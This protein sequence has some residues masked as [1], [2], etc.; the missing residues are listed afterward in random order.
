MATER[1]KGQGRKSDSSDKSGRKKASGKSGWSKPDGTPLRKR[2]GD[3]FPDKE[4]D[5]RKPALRGRYNKSESF[6]KD[7]DNDRPR[8]YKRAEGDREARSSDSPRE[9]KK[10]GS[11]YRDRDSDK[12][13]EYSRTEGASGDR[14]D[15]PREYKKSGTGFRDRDSKPRPENRFRD[16]DPKPGEYKKTGSKYG[17]FKRA[18]FS[19]NQD[20]KPREYTK[21]D[22]SSL[23]SEIRKPREYGK[24]AFERKGKKPFEK[25]RERYADKDHSKEMRGRFDKERTRQKPKRNAAGP[26]RERKT[27]DDLQS[28]EAI[29]LNRYIANAGICSRREADDLISAGL[30]SINGEI[31]TELGTKVKPDDVVKFN[32]QTL[33]TEKLVYVLLN[34]PKDFITTTEDPDDRKT[35]MGLV[36]DAGRERIFPVGR[37][38][39]N[40]TGLLLLTND[41]ELTKRLTHPSGNIKK[42][43]QVELDRNLS[44]ADMLKAAEG[45]ELEDGP[46]AFDEI[47]YAS[48]DDKSII[49]VEL[50]SG[51]N[52]IVRRIFEELGYEVR[53]LDRTTFAGLT[54]KDLPRGRWRFLTEMEVNML[55]MLTGKKR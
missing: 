24:P 4:I 28:K 9:F 45:V 33:K 15:K 23:E 22:D 10:S 51:K 47:Q 40:T 55:K 32:D 29:R 20:D 39:R 46:A 49:G 52:R 14:D 53:K 7:R 44:Q 48:T 5:K 12:P 13:R 42:L 43:Y 27:A 35:V 1:G 18:G 31:V 54:K 17:D 3:Y 21:R 41:G 6:A 26:H 25:K 36:K 50:H 2:K 16:R 30:V 11:S 8:D 38:D 34:K 37:L 19:R